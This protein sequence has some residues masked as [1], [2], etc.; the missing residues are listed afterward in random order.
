MSKLRFALIAVTLMCIAL[1]SCAAR[2]PTPCIIGDPGVE[3]MT[4]QFVCPNVGASYE[5]TVIKCPR[6]RHFRMDFICQLCGHRHSYNLTYFPYP[7]RWSDFYFYGGFWYQSNYW[8][9][10]WPYHR[11]IYRPGRPAMMVPPARSLPVRPAPAGPRGD[12]VRNPGLMQDQQRSRELRSPTPPTPRY[13]QP[14][15]SS[16]PRPESIRVA[17]P[18][19]TPSPARGQSGGSR[20]SSRSR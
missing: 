5:T 20:G 9:R 16:P 17:P 15:P 2:R 19:S 10:Y 11:P 6:D 12:P 13:V 7:Y 14:A 18:A 3:V 1:V 8:Q 4:I